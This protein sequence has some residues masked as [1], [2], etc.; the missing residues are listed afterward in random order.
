[1]KLIVLFLMMI[2]AAGLEVVGIGMIPAFVA[3]VAAPERVM[4]LDLLQPLFS[5]LG[6]GTDTDLLLWGALALLGVFVLKNVYM[7]TFAYFEAKYLFNRRYIISHRLMRAYMRAPYTFHL[8]RNTAELLRNATG[9]VNV[10]SNVILSNILK[11]AKNGLMAVSIFAFLLYVEPLITLMI[12]VLSGLGAGSFILLTQ[13]KMKLYGEEEQERR[14]EMIKAVYQGLNGLKETRVLNR[15]DEFIEKYRYEAQKST[16]LMAWIKF[17]QQVPKP[18]VEITAVL[19]ML[20]IASILVWQG[21]PIGAIIPV[22]TLFAMAVVRLMPNIQALSSMYTNLRYNI[23]SLKPIYEDLKGLENA[24]ATLVKDRANKN[25]LKLKEGIEVCNLGFSYPGSSEKAINGVNLSIKRGQAIALVGESGAGKTTMVDLL[26]GLLKPTEG[27]ILVDGMNIHDH[28]S[29]W[30]RNIGYIPQSIY[31]ADD[32]LRRNVAF[33]VPEKEIDNGRVIEAI[34][35]AQ[36]RKTVGNLPDGI[37]TIVGEQ[38]ARLSG[39]Q[40]QRVGIARALYHDPQILVMDEATSAL[41]NITENNII[42]AIENLKGERTIITI[43]H[44]LTTVKNC[45]QLYLMEEGRIVQHGSY[46]ELIDSN[47]AFRKM[48]LE[49]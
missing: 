34:E 21:R 49:I 4:E 12:F 47:R 41:D 3:I 43:A 19:G 44:R 38:G 32:T 29:G 30:Q 46:N 25:Q 7:I 39:G 23:I 37:E 26:L 5:Y 11:M 2:V 22:L 33:G 28:L 9:E 17:I 31:M 20:L 48:A 40:R 1:M 8:Q 18:V 35:L 27:D 6:I 16:K 10:L 45:D 36:L 13:K 15:E 42:K 14:K 24:S